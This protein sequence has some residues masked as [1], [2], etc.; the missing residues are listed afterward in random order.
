[1]VVSARMDGV[2]PLTRSCVESSCVQVVS[3]ALVCIVAESTAPL[4]LLKLELNALRAHLSG[5]L[6]PIFN[7]A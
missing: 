6:A 3:N 4:G 1:M 5:A 7:A 2:P